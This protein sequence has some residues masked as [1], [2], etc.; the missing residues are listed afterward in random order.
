MNTQW[1][2]KTTIPQTMDGKPL[3][4]LLHHYWLLP[5]H[6]VFSL[7]SDERILV[8]NRYL[9]VN[10]PVHF[11]D[12]ISLTFIPSDFQHPFPQVLPDSA[13]TLKILYEDA[14]LIV[15]NKR[16]GNKTHPNQP[17]EVGATINHLAAYLKTKGMLPYM[18]HR[19]DQETSGAILF[20]KNPAVVPTLVA[21]I[22]AKNIK[23]TYLA[24][25]EGTDIDSQGIIDF[26][27]GLDPN[28]KRKRMI[29][30]S[31]PAKSL[32]HYTVLQKED[33]FS[34]LAVQLETGRTHQIRVHLA[35]IGHPLV[36]DPLY[37]PDD[38]HPFLLLH[39]WKLKIPLPF[40][41]QVIEIT[42]P[43]PAHFDDFK[44]SLLT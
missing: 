17:G 10:F 19:L 9:P 35:A 38:K 39:S 8:N 44:L 21:K 30:G 36:G 6:L 5:K 37:N 18:V 43:L 14:N 41:E 33:G 27:I 42:A 15:I 26:P 12:H 16:R 20:A 28:D 25:V 7:R 29:G 24:W 22:A 13:A 4:Y 3:R 34:L 23:R 1:L 31:H 2:F 11:H 40:S 32:T